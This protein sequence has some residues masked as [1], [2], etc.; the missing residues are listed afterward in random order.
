M[1]TPLKKNLQVFFQSFFCYHQ[2]M[3][4]HFADGHFTSDPMLPVSDLGIVRGL[5]VFDYLR[6]YRGRPFHL[7][8]HLLR[9]QYSAKECGIALPS[10]LEEIVSIVE[11]LLE[12][13]RFTES[14]IKIV[15]TGGESLDQISFEGKARLTILISPLNAFHPPSVSVITTKRTRILPQAKTTNYISAVLALQEAKTRGAQDALYVSG[16]G[17]IL[18]STTSNFFGVK[19]GMIITPPC[20]G[21][22]LGITRAVVLKIAR[23]ATERE[24]LQEEVLDEAFLT[25]STREILPIHKIDGRP[26]NIGP[27]T[28]NLMEKFRAYT[29]VGLWEDLEINRHLSERAEA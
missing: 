11:A 8:D 27:I 20:E 2:G 25:S 24:I 1:N 13:N 18:E 23:E 7:W 21:I 5:A 12:K 26:M 6:T 19:N 22:L 28:R 9:L 14:G 16:E 29:E 4:I 17:R 15:V 10:P 3:P